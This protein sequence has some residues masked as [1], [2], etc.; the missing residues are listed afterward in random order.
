MTGF[1]PDLR[2]DPVADLSDLADDPGLADRIRDEIRASGPLPFAR[3]ME[4]A[5]YDP[6]GG[7]YRS[8]EPRPGRR[9]DFITAPELHPI[10]G[11]LLAR[12][13]D[14]AWVTLGRPDPFVVVEHGAGEGALAVPLLG[15][16]SRAIDYHPVEVDERRVAVLRER[17]TDAGLGGRLVDTLPASFDGVIV[18][19][20]VL[21][22]LPVHRVVRRNDALR[23]LA[24]DIAPD[25]S[26][27]DV[28]IDPTTPALGERLAVEGI[29]LVD[30]QTAEIALG[31]DAWVRD[32]AAPLRH[33][34]LILIDY[35]APA[36]ELYDPVRR[37]DGT[38]QAYVR[39]QLSDDPYRFVGRQDLTAHVDVSAVQRAAEAAGLTILGVTTQAEALMA[40]GVE[41]RLREIQADPMT[42]MEGYTLLRASLLRL[43][44][45]AAM[46]RFRVMVFG[47]GW[48]PE[49]APRILRY[50]LPRSGSD[51]D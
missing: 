39:H 21:D 11:E 47:R 28:E 4:L 15:V 24:V 16:L 51:A 37:R 41:D 30:G 12:E 26:F 33:G 46:G 22:A 10:F 2:R 31:L 25:G 9:G 42:T 36:T 45:P 35:G 40:L 43:L 50:R 27:V 7:Y 8:S 19:N 3:F 5:L 49:R 18:A 6:D 14:D 23:E 32:A 13:V 34:L 38:L 17:L 44:D 1:R 29:D 20:E 48:P